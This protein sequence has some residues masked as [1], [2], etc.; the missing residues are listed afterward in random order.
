MDNLLDTSHLKCE[1]DWSTL[2]SIRAP[3]KIKFFIW[4]LL[5][6]CLPTRSNLREKHINCNIECV[7]C[8][9]NIEH[10]WHLFISRDHAKQFWLHADLWHH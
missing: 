1:G 2:W 9:S 4:R 10:E 3:P 8:E 5:R 7:C 6:G